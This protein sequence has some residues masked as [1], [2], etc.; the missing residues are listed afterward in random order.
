MTAMVRSTEMQALLV[1]HAN[2]PFVI[3]YDT[4]GGSTLDDSFIEIE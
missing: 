2:G 3:V 4:V 1:G